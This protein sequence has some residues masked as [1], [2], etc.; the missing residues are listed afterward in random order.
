MTAPTHPNWCDADCCT[1][2]TVVPD[3]YRPGSG[4]EHRSAPITVRLSGAFPPVDG[5]AEAWLTEA[6]APWRCVVHLRLRIGATEVFIPVADA[7][8]ELL[9]L[10]D[11][12]ARGAGA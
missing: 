2:W 8:V 5:D 9:A 12:V 1:A 10:G 7:Q 6:V 3:S 4:G 11:L